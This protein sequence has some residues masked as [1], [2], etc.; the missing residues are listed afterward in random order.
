MFL[1]QSPTCSRFVRPAAFT[2]CVPRRFWGGMGGMGGVGGRSGEGC[3][4]PAEV[5]R[6]SKAWLLDSDS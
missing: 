3:I 6:W 5:G 2:F 4:E 1:N